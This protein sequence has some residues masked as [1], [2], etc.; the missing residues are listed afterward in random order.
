MIAELAGIRLDY[1]DVSVERK[2]ALVRH[3]Y[4]GHDGADLEAQGWGPGEHRLRVVFLE[5]RQDD[6]AKLQAVL[7]NG[8]S[9]ELQHPEKGALKGHVESISIRYDERIDTTEVEITFVED[10]IHAK[11]AFR[12]SAQDVAAGMRASSQAAAT[13]QAA[14]G[15]GLKTAPSPDLADPT[16]L[17]KL[18]DLGAVTNA[19]V[20]AMAAQIGRLDGLIVRFTSPVSAAFAALEWTAD[21]PSQLAKRIGTVLDLMQGKVQGSPSPALSA[22][23]F[24]ANAKAFADTFTGTDAEGTARIMTAQQGAMTVAAVMADDEVRIRAMRAYEASQSFDDEGRWVG[25]GAQ[26]EQ[27]PATVTQIE[28]LVALSRRLIQQARPWVE[29]PADLD[30]LALALQDSFRTRLVE[31]EKLREVEIL[32]PTPLHLICHQYGLPYNVAERLVILNQ[33]RNPS[34]V[35]GR[36]QIYA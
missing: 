14:K 2:L 22:K 10:G 28:E 1:Q 3:E 7:A 16:W 18:G 30:R 11:P 19:M 5:D 25:R 34:F 23:K 20:R 17:E 21:L 35:Q 13:S 12:P 4:P 33:I 9:M 26:P 15:F 31:F 36:I 6:W 27:L 29:D 8:A 32:V 24:L